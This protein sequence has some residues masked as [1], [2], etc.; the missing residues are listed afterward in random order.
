MTQLWAFYTIKAGVVHAFERQL[1]MDRA[2]IDADGELIVQ[3][4]TSLPQL[5]P[6]AKPEETSQAARC[7]H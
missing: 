3:G 2:S 5:L 1:G 7:C 4:A 6:G